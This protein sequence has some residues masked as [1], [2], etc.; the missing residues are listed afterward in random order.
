MPLCM[1]VKKYVPE[2]KAETVSPSKPEKKTEEKVVNQGI[3]ECEATSLESNVPPQ[4]QSPPKG[5]GK[6]P[7]SGGGS[8]GRK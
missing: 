3:E 1:G 5:K 4:A 2:H 6:N 7:N 8:G